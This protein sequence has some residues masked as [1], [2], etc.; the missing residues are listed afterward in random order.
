[1]GWKKVTALFLISIV[2]GLVA[3]WFLGQRGEQKNEQRA[4]SQRKSVYDSLLQ[5]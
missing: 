4:A 5:S 1:M 2:L 3:G